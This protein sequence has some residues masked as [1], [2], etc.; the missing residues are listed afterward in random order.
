MICYRLLFY[1]FNIGISDC[2]YKYSKKG[3]LEKHQ[4]N[5]NHKKWGGVHINNTDIDDIFQINMHK[6]HDLIISLCEDAGKTLSVVSRNCNS[7][8]YSNNEYLLSNEGLTLQ[9]KLY[10]NTVVIASEL[11]PGYASKK[12]KISIKKTIEQLKFLTEIYSMG[13]KR[14][15]DK[16]SS[17]SAEI[18]FTIIG[19]EESI[20]KYP[21]NAYIQ[22]KLTI[23]NK[24]FFKLY[25]KLDS[26]T[27]KSYFSKTGYAA[28]VKCLN[29]LVHKQLPLQERNLSSLTVKEL[30]E[31]L[32]N[33]RLLV[34]G[35]KSVLIERIENYRAS[36]NNNNNNNNAIVDVNVGFIVHSNDQIMEEDEENDSIDNNNDN[37]EE[38]NDVEI[39]ERYDEIDENYN[40]PF[41]HFYTIPTHTEGDQEL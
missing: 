26:Y 21:D 22:S 24:P 8:N 37:Y 28:A 17:E 35:K 9:H 10:D 5:G 2:D 34:S 18:L 20:I 32:S 30:K 3:W 31:I 15:A 7:T 16:L 12:S 29:D 27:I 38:I 36:T 1:Y 23:D 40:N 14:V 6:K 13:E 4:A 19:T 11:S 33:A 25:E 41:Y 39:I